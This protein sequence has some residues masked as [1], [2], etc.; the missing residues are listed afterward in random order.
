LLLDDFIRT[1]SAEEVEQLRGAALSPRRKQVLETFLEYRSTPLPPTDHLITRSGLTRTN[2]YRQASALLQD[3]YRVLA[4]NE[5]EVLRLLA[6][7]FLYKHF[8]DEFE[9]QE[10]IYGDAKD[11]ERL[12]QLYEV[13]FALIFRFEVKTFDL[14]FARTLAKK[15]F[16]AKG[17]FDEERATYY[18]MRSVFQEIVSLPSRKR[19]K[20]TDMERRARELLDAIESRVYQYGDVRAKVLFHDAKQI[21]LDY[22]EWRPQERLSWLYKNRELFRDAPAE[23]YRTFNET[24]ELRIAELEAYIG[25]WAES[26]ATYKQYHPTI[27]DV[28]KR[29]YLYTNAY[30]S[31]ALIAGDIELA[32]AITEQA[33]NRE[34]AESNEALHV[35]GITHKAHIALLKGDLAAARRYIDRGLAQN[36]EENFFFLYEVLFRCDEV[37]LA[38]YEGK[39]DL[40]HQLTGRNKKW[41]RSRKY[42]LNVTSWGH[43]LTL[44]EELATKK[45]TGQPI[46]R[47]TLQRFKTDFTGEWPQ[48]AR[49]VANELED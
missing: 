11:G 20:I 27:E 32:E 44:L 12:A 16:E 47:S 37:V 49:L 9:R 42:S 40:V 28:V 15:Y 21:M 31:I 4:E 2:F 13:A 6:T 34:L 33:F 35:L 29:G 3:C 26:L 5:T 39:Y 30:I 1:L 18:E 7:K 14:E 41:L 45:H 38:L 46:K 25:K 17:V 36:M 43:F 10:Q 48:Y 24:N 19:L 22:V 23:Q 8:I